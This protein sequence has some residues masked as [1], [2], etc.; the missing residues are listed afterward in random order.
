MPASSAGAPAR[1]CVTATPT[2]QW[3]N[4]I[5]NAPPNNNNPFTNFI[6]DTVSGNANVTITRVAGSHT[7]KGGYYYFNS[8]QKRGQGNIYGTINFAN[9]GA[10]PLDTGYGFANA[11]LG[12]F[13][14]DSGTRVE[15]FIDAV[16]DAHNAA[17][18]LLNLAL[19]PFLNFGGVFDL[20]EHTHGFGICAAV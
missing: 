6:L 9:D 7:L 20:Q 1:T 4:R 19:E 11:A 18:P 2:F 17:I 14:Q 3:G 8:V 15:R 5:A 10:N 12:V 13:T 16:A